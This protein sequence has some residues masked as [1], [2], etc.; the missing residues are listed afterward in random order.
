MNLTSQSIPIRHL[1]RKAF[2]LIETMIAVAIVGIFFVSL[3]TGI[4]QGFGIM[5]NTRE[6]LRATQILL[7]R[8]EEMRLYSWDQIKTY[9]TTNSFVPSAFTEAFYPRT[10]NYYE[11]TAQIGTSNASGDFVYYG[12]ITVTN[13]GLTNSYNTNMRK[14][15]VTLSWTNGAVVRS[16]S[17]STFV[18]EYG[19]Q[20][21][22]Y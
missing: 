12:T 14:V 6:N 13:A 21:Y 5:A 19:I 20:K 3:Y 11:S 1:G 8:M 2:T 18:S 7:D 16:H 9:G 15:I 22:I 10:T 4:T 17:I